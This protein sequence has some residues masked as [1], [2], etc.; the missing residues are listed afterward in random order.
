MVA[1]LLAMAVFSGLAGARTLDQ[2]P[3]YLEREGG[4]VSAPARAVGYLGLAIGSVV[5]LPA[6]IVA[7]PFGIAAGDPLGYVLVPT[8][9]GATGGAEAGYHI[10]GALPWVL[11]KGFYDAPMAG[12]ARVKGVPPSGL[13][14][15][16][17]P[18]EPDLLALQYL[19]ST[20]AAARVPVTDTPRV[21]AALPP[22]PE[23]TSLILFK[24]SISPFKPPPPTPASARRTARVKS[25]PTATLP[26]VVRAVPQA[27]LERRRNPASRTT[28]SS[29]DNAPVEPS[30]GAAAPGLPEP[31]RPTIRKRRGVSSFLPF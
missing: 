1:V 29:P 12:I 19:E 4:F 27:E 23:A 28:E 8:S 21:S 17:E 13:V 20:P 25:A 16:I 10:G 3:S 9:V 31:E 5:A 2:V 26:P 11:K 7:L 24:R 22:P 30:S 18:R 14:A 6:S 15:E